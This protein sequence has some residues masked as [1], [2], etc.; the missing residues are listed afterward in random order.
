MYEEL[1]VVEVTCRYCGD[2]TS[3]PAKNKAEMAVYLIGHMTECSEVPIGVQAEAI[4]MMEAARLG[5]L[6]L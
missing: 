3:W 5:E 1:E 2:A 4:V 6:E